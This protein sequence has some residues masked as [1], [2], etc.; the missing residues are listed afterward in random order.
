M[1]CLKN[2]KTKHSFVSNPYFLD[3]DYY[4]SLLIKT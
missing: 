3:L 4:K 2:D 1:L